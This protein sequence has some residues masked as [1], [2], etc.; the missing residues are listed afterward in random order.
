MAAFFSRFSFIRFAEAKKAASRLRERDVIFYAAVSVAV[1]LAVLLVFDGYFFFAV[2][3]R[4]YAPPA[5]V[6]SGI[7]LSDKEI[8]GV[9]RLLDE[10]AEKFNAIMGMR[11]NA[12]NLE[13]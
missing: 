5:P 11:V 12:T 2:A 8:D 7:L 4:E 10:R 6:P 13:K 3:G 9:I 1:L